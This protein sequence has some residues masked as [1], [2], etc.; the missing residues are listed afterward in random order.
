MFFFS[1]LFTSLCFF[2]SFLFIWPSPSPFSTLIHFSLS[3]SLSLSFFLSRFFIYLSF[4]FLYFISF[5][6]LSFF[7]LYLY[8]DICIYY[9]WNNAEHH[10]SNYPPYQYDGNCQLVG[11][12]GKYCLLYIKQ[13]NQN[14]AILIFAIIDCYSCVGGV[15]LYDY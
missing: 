8:T 5:Y 12:F 4:S 11:K 13:N 7:F 6:S 9:Q 1:N 3:L 15:V 10:E 2:L 14:V